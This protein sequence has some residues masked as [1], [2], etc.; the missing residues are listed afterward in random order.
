MRNQRGSAI[1]IVLILLA[2]GGLMGAG[3]MLQSQLN[4][5][6]TTAKTSRA[7]SL[8]AADFAAQLAYQHVRNSLSTPETQQTFL[9][10]PAQVIYTSGQDSMAGWVA[11][12][13][14]RGLLNSG[15]AIAGDEEGREGDAIQAWVAMGVADR[16]AGWIAGK[17]YNEGQRVSHHGSTFECISTHT[18]QPTNEP[19]ESYSIE[20]QFNVNWQSKWK[21]VAPGRK[22]VQIAVRKKI[23]RGE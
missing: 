8:N 1:A 7:R 21:A 18:A 4:T 23:S 2:A 22:V 14:Y 17:T 19:G 13:Q 10:R 15:A 9:T 11:M 3:L 5:K 12:R 20:G 16:G 6:I